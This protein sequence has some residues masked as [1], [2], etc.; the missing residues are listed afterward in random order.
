MLKQVILGVVAATFVG[1]AMAGDS[2]SDNPY[3]QQQLSRKSETTAAQA[4]ESGVQ[5]IKEQ[6][7]AQQDLERAGFPQY[8]D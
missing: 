8:A 1:T 3:W 6:R 2:V 7:A 5:I 4:R